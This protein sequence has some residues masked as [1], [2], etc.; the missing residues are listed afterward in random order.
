MNH[1]VN[2]WVWYLR[3][4]F[5]LNLDDTNKKKPV[6]VKSFCILAFLNKFVGDPHALFAVLV[7]PLEHLGKVCHREISHTPLQLLQG[8]LLGVSKAR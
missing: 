5:P 8:G 1:F 3:N 4:V 2:L 6:I 7:L